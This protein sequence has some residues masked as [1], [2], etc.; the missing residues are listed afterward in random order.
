MS[1]RLRRILVRTLIVLVLLV[2]LLMMGGPATVYGP[3][4]W[5]AFNEFLEG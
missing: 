2:A 4:A 5:A 3:H 1:R